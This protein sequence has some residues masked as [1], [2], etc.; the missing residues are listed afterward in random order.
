MLKESGF[1]EIGSFNFRKLITD[2]KINSVITIVSEWSG[3]SQLL[4]NVMNRVLPQFSEEVQFFKFEMK[5]PGKI[6]PELYIRRIPTTLLIK[7]GDIVDYFYGAES[8][9]RIEQRLSEQFG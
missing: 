8:K 3:Q 6:S 1:Q 7:D 9:K 4:V 2:N 5:N